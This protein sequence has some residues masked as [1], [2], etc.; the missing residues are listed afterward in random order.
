[1]VGSLLFT[2]QGKRW[3]AITAQVLSEP[4][5]LAILFIGTDDGHLLR[6]LPPTSGNV[7]GKIIS[8]Q[9]VFDETR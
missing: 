5:N 3:T 9:N 4:Q 8:D 7:H 2:N 6:A 1:M